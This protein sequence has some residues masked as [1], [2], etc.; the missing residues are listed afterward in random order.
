MFKKLYTELLKRTVKFDINS[1]DYFLRSALSYACENG[2]IEIVTELLNN[3]AEI[4]HSKYQKHQEDTFINPIYFAIQNNHTDIVKLMIE[5]GL[6]MEFIHLDM[7]YELKQP[8]QMAVDNDNVEIVSLLIKYGVD[9]SNWNGIFPF[10]DACSRGNHKIVQAFIDGGMRGDCTY[11]Y[12]V[13]RY[14][15]D[16]PRQT[17]NVLMCASTIEVVRI[18]VENGGN[19]NAVTSDGRTVLYINCQKGNI[20]IVSY[21]IDKGAQINI[22]T[23]DNK[24]P[25]SIAC[26]NN[27]VEIVNL[28]LITG[29]D[30]SNI[31]YNQYSENIKSLFLF[32]EIVNDVKR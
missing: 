8:L 22:T 12:Q 11:D 17:E 30:I 20:D 2:N 4:D 26:E 31:D 27:N 15:D 28:L 7:S 3:G 24:T 32:N 29:A 14:E 6:D 1:I 5:K 9:L 25:L 21:L 10:Y 19:L 18:L 16:D 13:Q 23:H